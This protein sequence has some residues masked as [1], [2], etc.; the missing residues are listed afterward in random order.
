MEYDFDKN[1]CDGIGKRYVLFSLGFGKHICS[2][3]IVLLQRVH[4]HTNHWYWSRNYCNRLRAV[5][6]VFSL[7]RHTNWLPANIQQVNWMKSLEWSS[8]EITIS[9]QHISKWIEH[10]SILWMCMCVCVWCGFADLNRWFVYTLSRMRSITNRKS[11]SE[12]ERK[13]V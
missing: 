8:L 7:A 10:S 6:N 2:P 1:E 5:S 12:S 4:P 9:Y 13:L 11:A 3:I